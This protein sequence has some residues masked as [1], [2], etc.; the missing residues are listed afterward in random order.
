MGLYCSDVS[1]AFD[2]VATDRLLK[3]LEARGVQGRVLKL[4]GS[5][6]QER[7]AV[8]VVDAQRSSEAVLQNMVCQGTV[9]EAPLWNTYFCDSQTAVV[10]MDGAVVLALRIEELADLLFF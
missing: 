9:W 2:R 5:W 8:V 7:R 3:K 4:L 1:G 6:L 10:A